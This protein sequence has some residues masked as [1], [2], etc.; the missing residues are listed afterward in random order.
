MPMPTPGSAVLARSALPRAAPCASDEDGDLDSSDDDDDEPVG[1]GL[2]ERLRSMQ[3]NPMHIRYHGKSSGAKLI[4]DAFSVKS[5]LA[6]PITRDELL[7]VL[8]GIP[9]RQP[10]HWQGYEV[11]ICIR[12]QAE[13]TDGKSSGRR[14]ICR[15]LIVSLP[16]EHQSASTQLGYLRDRA[17]SIYQR[18]GMR[19]RHSSSLLT[20]CSPSSSTRTSPT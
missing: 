9:G 8:H 2:E 5:E 10:E 18:P 17:A 12:D 7:S 4:M 11:R 16:Q 20:I 19:R 1:R 3:L 15:G 13:L 6:S 14:S